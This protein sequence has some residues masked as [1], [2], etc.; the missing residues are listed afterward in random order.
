MAEES[1]DN[2][3]GSL[4]EKLIHRALKYYFEPDPEKHE[5]EYKGYV[6]DIKNERGITEI[7]SRSFERL[8]QKL[9]A[10]LEDERVTVV[11]PIV[12]ESNIFWVDPES[13]EAEPPRRGSKKGRAS[14]V[15]Y[16]LSR[17]EKYLSSERFTL[18][19]VFL[20]ADDYRLL[21]GYGPNR[22]KRATKVD[23]IPREL[24]EIREYRGLEALSHLIP[25]TLPETFTARDFSR[26]T[27][28]RG[29]KASFSLSFCQRVGFI[30]RVG[31]QANAFIYKR[32]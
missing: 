15:L 14:D 2:S 29:R 11:Y 21:D 7:Q 8:S 3:I 25:D 10:F 31:K 27:A 30:E 24:V 13:G 17:I 22:K 4:S 32:V 9:K 19:L 5:V 20:T 18:R 1:S 26:A 16:E 6:C 23:R 12:S 28:L